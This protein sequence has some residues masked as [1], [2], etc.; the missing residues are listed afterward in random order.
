MRYFLVFSVLL[1]GL[2]PSGPA[3]AQMGCGIAPIPPIPQI[4]CR[5]MQPRCVCDANG[6]CHWEFVCVPN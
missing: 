2:A 1:A 4:G 5:A 3:A 6:S